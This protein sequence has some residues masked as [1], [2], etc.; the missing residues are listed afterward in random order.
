MTADNREK[1]P[2]FIPSL[3]ATIIPLVSFIFLLA[4]NNINSAM[5]MLLFFLTLAAPFAAMGLS[6]AGLADAKKLQ[7]PFKGCVFCL[8]IAFFE[9]LFLI[10]WTQAY[11]NKVSSKEPVIVQAHNSNP[12]EIESINEEVERIM[13][14]KTERGTEK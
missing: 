5:T 10:G 7:E 3:I 2:F 9:V 8:V 14:G 4:G 13:N 1:N 6:V 12:S 11:L